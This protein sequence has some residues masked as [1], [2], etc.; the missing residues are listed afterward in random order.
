MTLTFIEQ[1]THDFNESHLKYYSLLLNFDDVWSFAAAKAPK[2]GTKVQQKGRTITCDPSKTYPCG[3]VCRSQSKDCKTPIEGQAKNYAGFLELQGKKEGKIKPI[4]EK[5]P[6]TNEVLE[7]S[8]HFTTFKS[9]YRKG[10]YKVQIEDR[11]T[12][13][14][15]RKQEW[16][17]ENIGATYNNREGYLVSAAGVKKLAELEK[18]LDVPDADRPYKIAY[19]YQ[20]FLKGILKSQKQTTL[21]EFKDKFY[22]ERILPRIEAGETIKQEVLNDYLDRPSVQRYI[23]DNKKPDLKIVEPTKK[24]Q[25]QTDTK[26]PDLKVVDG[27]KGVEPKNTNE[28]Q[29]KFPK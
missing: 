6:V 20:P 24:P 23:K 2:I 29:A 13:S 15:K 9:R 17:L 12:T 25:K 22:E 26:T 28:L 16:L 3:A 11:N 10:Y 21:S 19:Y 5:K 18:Y 4:E 8:K 7:P 1:I 14:Y 27:G